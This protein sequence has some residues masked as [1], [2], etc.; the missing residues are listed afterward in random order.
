M[1]LVKYKIN[2]KQHSKQWMDLHGETQEVDG[3][4]KYFQSP[5]GGIHHNWSAVSKEELCFT[6]YITSS[7]CHLLWPLLSR[8]LFSS[9]SNFWF[10]L[11]FPDLIF[12]VYQFFCKLK[13]GLLGSWSQFTLFWIW[14]VAYQKF[15]GQYWK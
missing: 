15:G 8:L 5:I 13:W 7:L 9:L 10:I 6:S 4:G 1:Y 14:S 11:L 2:E 12:V 3:V